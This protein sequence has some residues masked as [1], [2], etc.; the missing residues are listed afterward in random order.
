MSKACEGLNFVWNPDMIKIY[1]DLKKKF[2]C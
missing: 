2:L 1:K